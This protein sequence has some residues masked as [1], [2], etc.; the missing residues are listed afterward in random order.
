MRPVCTLRSNTFQTVRILEG[1][2]VRRQGKKVEL[3]N[4]DTGEV[5]PSIRVAAQ[6]VL[7]G[8][9]VFRYHLIK[10]GEIRGQRFS[11]VSK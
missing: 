10:H 11:I 6:S 7:V 1:V 3:R 8:P 9:E 4:E 5:F 2:A